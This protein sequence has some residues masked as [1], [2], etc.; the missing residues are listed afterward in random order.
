MSERCDIGPGFVLPDPSHEG[1]FAF[2]IY[3]V[4]ADKFVVYR[5]AV[6]EESEDVAPPEVTSTTEDPAAGATA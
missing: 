1:K 4:A 6:V 2:I 5:G 3:D